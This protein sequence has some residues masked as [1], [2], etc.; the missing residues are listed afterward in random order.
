M[1]FCGHKNIL[2]DTV[3]MRLATR[4]EGNVKKIFINGFRLFW[5]DFRGF[6]APDDTDTAQAGKA[7]QRGK[8]C[9]C[10]VRC[11]CYIGESPY[12]CGENRLDFLI[13]KIFLFQRD[14]SERI[15]LF[16]VPVP[17]RAVSG[18]RETFFSLLLR[19]VHSG[20]ETPTEGRKQCFW[21]G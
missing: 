10:P 17:E 21:G 16:F 15:G 5:G 19:V 12:L 18:L 14:P 8:L 7:P 1:C 2:P 3:R 6:S 13:R 9:P 11:F 4:R 20:R